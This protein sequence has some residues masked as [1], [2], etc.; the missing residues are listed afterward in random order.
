M[1][2]NRCTSG[3]DRNALGKQERT[4]S[5]RIMFLSIPLDSPALDRRLCK[6]MTSLLPFPM[7]DREIWWCILGTGR[8]VVYYGRKPLVG[9]CC[10]WICRGYIPYVQYT[11]GVS[12]GL[13]PLKLSFRLIHRSLILQISTQ[14]SYYHGS[15]TLRQDSLHYLTWWSVYCDGVVGSKWVAGC[16][17]SCLLMLFPFC[18]LFCWLVCGQCV[19]WILSLWNRLL[20]K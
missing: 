7:G 18:D 20:L 10:S 2:T 12:Y 15:N 4:L 6:W 11:G 14:A 13:L 8:S 19:C 17:L 3:W 1:G 9:L 16:L 5:S